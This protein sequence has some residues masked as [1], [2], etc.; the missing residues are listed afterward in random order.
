MIG[1]TDH[2]MS[3]TLMPDGLIASSSRDRTVK[4]WDVETNEIKHNIPLH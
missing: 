4:I 1:H 2:I 3:L